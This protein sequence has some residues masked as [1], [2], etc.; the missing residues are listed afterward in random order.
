[1]LVVFVGHQ[2]LHVHRLLP[3]NELKHDTEEATRPGNSLSVLALDL[4]YVG[5]SSLFNHFK[6]EVEVPPAVDAVTGPHPDHT[7]T[8]LETSNDIR[9][10]VSSGCCAAV[11]R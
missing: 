6:V 11:G 9:H 3:V 8:N 5:D 10:D 7:L 2:L 1:M 4:A